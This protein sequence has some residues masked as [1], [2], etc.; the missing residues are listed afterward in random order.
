MKKRIISVPG[1]GESAGPFSRAGERAPTRK[2][3]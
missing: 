1:M 2:E 3:S